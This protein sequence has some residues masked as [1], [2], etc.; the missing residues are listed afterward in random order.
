MD[1]EEYHRNFQR[2]YTIAYGILNN[3]ED[4][5]DSAQDALLRVLKTQ[6]PWLGESQFSTWFYRVA[7]NC[8]LM[9]LRQRQRR[10]H[11]S[12]DDDEDVDF[13]LKD[14]LPAPSTVSPYYILESIERREL[15]IREVASLESMHVREVMMLY[16]LVGLTAINIAR[17][18]G[19]SIVAV[20]SQ[21]N[22][23]RKKMKK[24]LLD[25]G[26]LR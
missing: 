24:R 2:A 6:S 13:S 20:K 25:M 26:V 1:A 5:E 18:S 17:L 11:I 7:T 16:Y 21:L 9:R 4:A 22:R 19:M 10:K 12:I 3:R 23:G 8:A 15:V 14:N